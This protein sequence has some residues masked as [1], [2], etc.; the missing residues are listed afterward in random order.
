[1]IVDGRAAPATIAAG[2]AREGAATDGGRIGFW[3]FAAHRAG[4]R[5][6]TFSSDVRGGKREV[7]GGN[8]LA[9]LESRATSATQAL[10]P[11]AASLKTNCVSFE[12]GD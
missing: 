7:A 11:A 3:E 12:L 5:C 9:D 10:H 2:A 8:Q 1:M 6:G 4:G